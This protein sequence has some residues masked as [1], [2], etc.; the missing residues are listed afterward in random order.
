MSSRVRRQPATQYATP[1]APEKKA[2]RA[3]PSLG[4]PATVVPCITRQ[5]Y[6]LIQKALR[7]PVGA[8]ASSELRGRSHLVGVR[9]GVGVRVRVRRRGS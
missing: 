7:S 2:L 8:E 5:L 4:E 9:V 6:R 1:E 3:G